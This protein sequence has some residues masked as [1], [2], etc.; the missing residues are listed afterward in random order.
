MEKQNVHPRFFFYPF[1]LN[2]FTLNKHIQLVIQIN[3][4]FRCKFF[5]YFPVLCF[6]HFFYHGRPLLH[7]L[8]FE[9]M[10]FLN[11]AWASLNGIK[12]L[13]FM[14]MRFDILLLAWNAFS[15]SYW[16][17]WLKCLK[18]TCKFMWV[19]F[20]FRIFRLFLSVIQT[21]I[22]R[23]ESLWILLLNFFLKIQFV[24]RHHL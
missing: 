7:A 17:F 23:K 1:H 3:R 14:S 20:N 24:D 5:S 16:Q 11:I 22:Y 6:W 12:W 18:L 4:L 15:A 8:F 13:F 10:R 9:M 2:L 19:G 21:S